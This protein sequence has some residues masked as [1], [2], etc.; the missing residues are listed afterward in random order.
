VN[1][2]AHGKSSLSRSGQAGG[3]VMAM[4]VLEA[5]RE[6]REASEPGRSFRHPFPS[7]E[8]GRIE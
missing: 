6:R 7:H 4:K 2:R 1:A 3:A 8:H 5:R